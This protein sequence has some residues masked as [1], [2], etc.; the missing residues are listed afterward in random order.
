MR[1]RTNDDAS[2]QRFHLDA[3]ELRD[4][5]GEQIVIVY[6]EVTREFASEYFQVTIGQKTE[7]DNAFDD[8]G[9]HLLF[10]MANVLI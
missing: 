6:R 10:E 5:V 4:Q 8:H 1:R 2:A 3:I 7:S 9:V